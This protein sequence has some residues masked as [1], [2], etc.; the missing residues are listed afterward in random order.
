MSH[1]DWTNSQS[2]QQCERAPVS[3]QL[4]CHFNIQSPVGEVGKVPGGSWR[5]YSVTSLRVRRG[6][7]ERTGTRTWGSEDVVR[8]ETA[9]SPWGRRQG[10]KM[11]R[12]Q[13]SMDEP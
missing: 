8:E 12:G 10:L 3:L 11:G 13:H 9:Q 2:H 5:P 1:I 6:A 4:R 7:Q